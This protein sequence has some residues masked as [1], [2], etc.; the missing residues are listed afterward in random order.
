VRF[1]EMLKEAYAA[2]KGVNPRMPVISGG[3]FTS[4]VS[5]GYGMAD[6]AFL[7]AMYEAGAGGS[8]DAIG[9]HPYPITESL[10]GVPG[11]WDPAATQRALARIRIA[12]D[13]AGHASTPIW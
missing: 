10:D 1:T 6:A 7:S 13:A 9:F 11:H 2:V 12:L 8:L 4:S 3:L 5:G